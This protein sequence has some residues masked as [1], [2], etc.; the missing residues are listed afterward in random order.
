M[1]R[2]VITK[3][4]LIRSL[5]AF[6]VEQFFYRLFDAKSLSGGIEDLKVRFG[7]RLQYLRKQSKLTQAQLAEEMDCSVEF[8]SFMERG[9]NGASFPTLEKLASVFEIEVFE[10]FLFD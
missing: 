8:I 2:S 7:K 6:K 3:A 9:V 5:A 1:E 4:C 10:L